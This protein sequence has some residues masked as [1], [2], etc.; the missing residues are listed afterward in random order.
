MRLEAPSNIDRIRSL[1]PDRSLRGCDPRQ[2]G[3]P[4]RLC[5]PKA[6]DS[7]RGGV[8]QVVHRTW[9]A[10]TS[11]ETSISS[12]RRFQAQSTSSSDLLRCTNS[13]QG[14]SSSAAGPTAHSLAAPGRTMRAHRAA[15]RRAG[16]DSANW[17]IRRTGRRTVSDQP[18]T[19]KPA[20]SVGFPLRRWVPRRAAAVK[21]PF[22]AGPPSVPSGPFRPSAAG[23][24]RRIAPVI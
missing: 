3:I 5:S 1:Q 12:R 7:R 21:G 10:A 8:S 22:G 13:T 19:G 17:S 24:R 18:L 9:I 20:R 14:K 4:A 6:S 2:R 11:P 16:R 23:P 15:K